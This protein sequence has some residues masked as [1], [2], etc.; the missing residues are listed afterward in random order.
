LKNPGSEKKPVAGRKNRKMCLDTKNQIKRAGAAF[1]LKYG[2]FR[3]LS[4]RR[5]STF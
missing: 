2:R 4:N 1:S 5:K 3:K